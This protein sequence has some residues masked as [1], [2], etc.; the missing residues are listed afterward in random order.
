MNPDRPPIRILSVDIPLLREG[1]AAPLA[2]QP[3]MTLIAEASNGPEVIGFAC[4]KL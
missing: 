1:V 3:D 4:G 2:S